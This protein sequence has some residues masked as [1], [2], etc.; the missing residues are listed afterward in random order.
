MPD[1]KNERQISAVLQTLERYGRIERTYGH[2][3]SGRLRFLGDI[4]ALKIAHQLQ[5]TQ[6]SRFIYRMIGAFQHDLVDGV[7]C[8]LEEMGL[9]SGLTGDQLK[10]VLNALQNDVVE[11]V[12]PFSGRGIRLIDRCAFEYR[13]FP[14]GI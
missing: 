6:R 4:G 13:F 14:A 8:T 9:V 11:W 5:A 1:A 10:R 3:N 2:D 12:P 7:N